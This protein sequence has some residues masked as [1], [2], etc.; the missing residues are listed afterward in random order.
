LI[1]RRSKF[2]HVPV[3]RSSRGRS[4]AAQRISEAMRA[5]LRE[6]DAAFSAEL[7]RKL[8]YRPADGQ[9]AQ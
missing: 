5:R 9:P 8:S 6:S 7:E 2:N 4:E 3:S 1:R